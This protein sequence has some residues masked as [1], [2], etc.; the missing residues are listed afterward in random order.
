MTTGSLHPPYASLTVDVSDDL[1]A[2]GRLEVRI[3]SQTGSVP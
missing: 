3:V 1:P 2:E